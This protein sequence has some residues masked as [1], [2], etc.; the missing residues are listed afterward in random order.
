[1]L[2]G[3]KTGFFIVFTCNS[4]PFPEHTIF[5]LQASYVFNNVAGALTSTAMI[6]SMEIQWHSVTGLK[7]GFQIAMFNFWSVRLLNLSSVHILPTEGSLLLT[8]VDK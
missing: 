7:T 2:E 1:M 4:S 5:S 6:L 3:R 8:H